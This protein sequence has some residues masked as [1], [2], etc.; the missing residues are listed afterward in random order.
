MNQVKLRLKEQGETKETLMQ[1]CIK[2]EHPRERERWLALVLVAEGLSAHEVAR[3]LGRDR[4]TVAEWVTAFNQEGSAGVPPRFPGR[5]GKQLSEAQLEEVKQ[6]VDRP[7]REVG[8]KRAGWTCQRVADWV[9]R[10]WRRRVSAET[11][12]R[13]LHALDFRLKR[14]HKSFLKADPQAQEAFAE[15]L[16]HLQLQRSPRAQTVW[17][18]E[19]QIG[20]DA[21]LRRGWF[22]RGQPAQVP[23]CSPP[24]HAKLR[25]YVAILR[26]LGKV[27]T[28]VV[29]WFCQ[30]NT[31]RFLDKI[32]LWLPGWRLDVILDNAPWHRRA[33]VREAFQR[34]HL[35][36]HY[37]PAYS[38]QMNAAEPWIRW[39][40][41]DLSANL[42]W[43][44][45][46][47]LF[48]SFNGFVVSMCQRRV[49]IL[50]RCVPQLS[51]F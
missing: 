8:I 45:L 4:R 10:R 47:D 12:R 14:A 46:K 11:A 17:I 30:L 49:E 35:H 19:G 16:V 22:R 2:A 25:F 41:D 24:L 43:M 13:Y 9:K 40:K 32:R 36:P 15:K 44:D 48:R 37:L 51:G 21:L 31:A 27:I 7:P 34:N 5:P 39:A 50:R 3:R 28:L 6:T 42:C 33:L 38:P 23:S 1:R 18:D 29:D 26:P 20:Q